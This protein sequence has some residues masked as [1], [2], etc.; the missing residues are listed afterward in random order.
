MSEFTIKQIFNDHWDNFVVRNPELDIRLVVFK[1]V[2]KILTCGNPDYG[3]TIYVCDCCKKIVR[4][5]F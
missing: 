1:E 2:E 4:V 3:C 5:P